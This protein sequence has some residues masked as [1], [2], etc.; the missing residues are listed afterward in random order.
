MIAAKS[1]TRNVPVADLASIPQQEEA[2]A[3]LK[4]IVSTKGIGVVTAS[5]GTG[6]STVIRSL[7]AALDKT[8]YLICYINDANLTPK[9]LYTILLTSLGVEPPIFLERMKKQFKEAA[10]DLHDIQGKVLIVVIDNAQ[11]LPKPTIVEIRY[12]YS[13]DIDSK[14]IMAIL[15]L[16]HHDFW[17][18]LRLRVYEPVM[19][20]VNTH[21]RIPQL[22]EEQTNAYIRHHLALSGLTM[23]FP[24]DVVKR[25]HQ[26]SGGTP[27]V[28]NNL[29]IHCLI[30]MEGNQKEIVDNA[31]LD[32]VMADY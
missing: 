14:S 8:R 22:N 21:C 1:F 16:G 29:C 11:D 9:T 18:T 10:A 12:L 20:C 2:L 27:R 6:K 4:Y 13:Y 26:F 3:R 19:Q 31:V 25:I 32:R 24:D 30:D 5:P 7:E 15:L 28:I 23:S 17:D